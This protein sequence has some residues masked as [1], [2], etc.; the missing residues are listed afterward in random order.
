MKPTAF[1]QEGQRRFAALQRREQWLIAL[2]C[3]LAVTLLGYSL[4]LEPA[5]KQR[6][7]MQKTV[8]QQQAELA[9]L[10]RTLLVLEAQ[11]K[12]PQA[13]RRATL[14]TLRAQLAAI[15]REIGAQ[16]AGL[17]PPE[18]MPALLQTLLARH[19]GLTLMSLR[20]L[21]PQPLIDKPAAATT[22]PAVQSEDAAAGNLYRHGIEIKLAGSFPDLLAY[23]AE[24]DALPRKPMRGGLRLVVRQYPTSELTL[25]LYTLSQDARW[26]IV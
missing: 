10:E 18:Q 3:L 8:A 22:A 26:L 4:W 23:L 20:T 9:E 21:P 2:A 25:T 12:D 17:L 19:R 15:E 11:Q 5:L 6:T 14:E 24:L 16:G 13:A 1:W 7:L